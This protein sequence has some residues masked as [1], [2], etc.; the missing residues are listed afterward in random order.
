LALSIRKAGDSLRE[1]QKDLALNLTFPETLST[2]YA[3]GSP[4]LRNE[5]I[6]RDNQ[7]NSSNPYNEVVGYKRQIAHDSQTGLW[8][9]NVEAY[10]ELLT[11]DDPRKSIT[12]WHHK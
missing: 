5:A 8:D 10:E 11:G 2:G 6:R 7:L 12:E 4:L 1:L 3:A 9:K